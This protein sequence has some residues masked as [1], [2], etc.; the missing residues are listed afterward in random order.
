MKGGPSDQPKP[1]RH[2]QKFTGQGGPILDLTG[3][4]DGIYR[5]H[6]LS[7]GVGGIFQITIT[8]EN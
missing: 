4:P 3:L 7:C 2:D 5:P 6:M 1:L 8:T